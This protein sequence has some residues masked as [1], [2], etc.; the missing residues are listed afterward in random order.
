[1]ATPGTASLSPK[2]ILFLPALPLIHSWGILQTF[3]SGSRKDAIFPLI[4]QGSEALCK[5]NRIRPRDWDGP[6]HAPPPRAAPR[7]EPGAPPLRPPRAACRGWGSCL[8]GRRSRAAPARGRPGTAG[9]SAA[10]LPAPPGL[11]GPAPRGGR[12]PRAEP[13]GARTAAERARPG[14]DGHRDE[15]TAT[16]GLPAPWPGPY[17][18]PATRPWKFFLQYRTFLIFPLLDDLQILLS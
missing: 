13:A 7:P 8:A 4:L 15:G 10:L 12:E 17:K 14:P 1:M 5:A 16:Q 18:E 9:G 2:T 6:S 11:R 3:S